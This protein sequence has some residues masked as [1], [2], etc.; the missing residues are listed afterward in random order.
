MEIE[1]LVEKGAMIE[2]IM[3]H[4]TDLAAGEIVEAVDSADAASVFKG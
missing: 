1:A 4:V 2:G 3:V